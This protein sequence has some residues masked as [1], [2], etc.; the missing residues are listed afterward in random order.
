MRFTGLALLA[1]L[2]IAVLATGCAPATITGTPAP[3]GRPTFI[4][5]Y[6]DA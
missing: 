5:F 4:F 6:T 2:G 1:V 3:A